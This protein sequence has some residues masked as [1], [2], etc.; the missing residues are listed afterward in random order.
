M[1]FHCESNEMCFAAELLLDPLLA[2]SFPNSPALARFEG[3]FGEEEKEREVRVG[4]CVHWDE[5]P[6]PVA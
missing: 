6:W 5:R 4:H 2:R 1:F 3:R